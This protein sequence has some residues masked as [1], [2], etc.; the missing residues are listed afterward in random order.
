MKHYD[1]LLLQDM[2]FISLHKS[3]RQNWNCSMNIWFCI[4]SMIYNER[5]YYCAWNEDKRHQTGVTQYRQQLNLQRKLPSRNVCLFICTYYS[6]TSHLTLYYTTP[7]THCTDLI[8][9]TSAHIPQIVG[10]LH[11]LLVRATTAGN[12]VKDNSYL[13]YVSKLSVLDLRMQ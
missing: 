12:Y 4:T 8:H 6:I 11:P 9:T 3:M 1:S 10:F 7:I 2:N 13:N 5:K